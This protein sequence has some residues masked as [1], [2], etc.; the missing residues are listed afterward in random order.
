MV[1]A[2]LAQQPPQ[3]DISIFHLPLIGSD[4]SRGGQLPIDCPI[5]PCIRFETGSWAVSETLSVFAACTEQQRI[6]YWQIIA[7]ESFGLKDVLKYGII[8]LGRYMS[9]ELYQTAMS[10]SAGQ[11]LTCIRS[12]IGDVDV[13]Q[14]LATGIRLL[15]GL[16]APEK[17]KPTNQCSLLPSISCPETQKPVSL[18]AMSFTSAVGANAVFLG[19]SGHDLLDESLLSPFCVPASQQAIK[20]Q[21]FYRYRPTGKV[22]NGSDRS[23]CLDQELY[24]DLYPTVVQQTMLHHPIFDMLPWPDFRSAVIRAIYSNPPL[25]DANDLIVDLWNDGLRC[26]RL[27]YPDRLESPRQGLPW[28]SQSWEA[29][30]WF[31]E[32]WAVLTGGPDTDIRKTS[33]WWRSMTAGL[34]PQ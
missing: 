21:I 20:S 8:C 22:C 11:W 12:V 33:A 9:P 15:A 5:I 6:T 26:W 4:M 27:F 31:L 29:V 13:N 34:Q 3:H 1:S 23:L 25:I 28:Y 32:K 14:A 7:A 16:S 19:I 30:P 18:S 17:S 24:A 2:V 10:L